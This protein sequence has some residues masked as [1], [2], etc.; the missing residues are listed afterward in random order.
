MKIRAVICGGLK[1][2]QSM[3]AVHRGFERAGCDCTYLPT[4]SIRGGRKV[5]DEAMTGP[6]LNAV[7]HADLLFWW[8]PQ[9]VAPTLVLKEI[10]RRRPELPLV[11]QT[12]DDPQMWDNV[13]TDRI[14][15]FDYAVTSCEDTPPLYRHHGVEPIVGY[16]P[17]D[18]DL[19]GK[20]LPT[21]DLDFSFVATNSYDKTLHPGVFEDRVDIVK[22]LLP[23]GR[24]KVFGPWGPGKRGWARLGESLKE[25]VY[26]GWKNYQTE[27]PGIYAGTRINLTSHFRP[28]SR[29]PF[30]ERTISCMASGGFTLCDRIGGIEEVFA[31]GKE[32]ALWGDLDELVEKAKW[33]L[34]HDHHR[35]EVA[36]AGRRKALKLFDNQTLAE[37][38]LVLTM[39]EEGLRR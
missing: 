12:I 1:L 6:L 32:I 18:R 33:Y 2:T 8:Q 20:A 22:A 36:A 3:W 17:C 35:A 31:D 25:K 26:G 38:V 15:A 29:K 4:D 39:P 23:L 9:H 11:M 10:K 28:A 24:L 21:V 14:A 13:D 5:F 19:H 37:R 34:S 27:L 30:N 16:P 7:E